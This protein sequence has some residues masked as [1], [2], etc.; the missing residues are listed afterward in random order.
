M[1]RKHILTFLILACITMAAATQGHAT[2]YNQIVINNKNLTD[3]QFNEYKK[4]LLDQKSNGKELFTTLQK[5]G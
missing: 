2:T 5:I 4:S 3:A 1:K